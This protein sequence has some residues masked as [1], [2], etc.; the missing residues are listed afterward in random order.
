MNRYIPESSRESRSTFSATGVA[1]VASP[2]RS[3]SARWCDVGLLMPHPLALIRSTVNLP[4]RDAMT[5]LQAPTC[6]WLDGS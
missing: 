3:T 2:A 4:I 5:K 1:A 6:V